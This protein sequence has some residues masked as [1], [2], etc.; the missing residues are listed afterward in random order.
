MLYRKS[1]E[2]FF[3]KEVQVGPGP[4]ERRLQFDKKADVLDRG[5]VDR[6]AALAVPKVG[7]G[8]YVPPL[9][10]GEEA[11]INMLPLRL[12]TEVF[13]A[14]TPHSVAKAKTILL[15][16]EEPARVDW[17]IKGGSFWS[18]EDPRTPVCQRIVDLHQVEAV[19]TDLLAF[20]EDVAERN[21]FA[22]L[23]RQAVV[24]PGAS[25]SRKPC[26]SSL[27]LCSKL[28]TVTLMTLPPVSLLC[29]ASSD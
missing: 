29:D 7:F 17:V 27:V 24:L 28:S 19:D 11:V 20:H 9:G 8:Y 6:L 26:S 2:T 25:A 5:A 13:V 12:P 23:L 21:N 14:T 16:A 22:F 4:P 10:G 3:W 18:F 1:D 15:D